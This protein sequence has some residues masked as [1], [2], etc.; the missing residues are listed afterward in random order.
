MHITLVKVSKPTQGNGART[1]AYNV[2]K[3]LVPHGGG[4]VVTGHVDNVGNRLHSHR[5]DTGE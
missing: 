1:H 2:G 4:N 3:G 5:G